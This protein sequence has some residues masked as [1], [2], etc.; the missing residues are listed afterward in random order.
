LTF[1]DDLHINILKFVAGHGAVVQPASINVVSGYKQAQK[2]SGKHQ[3]GFIRAVNCGR[4]RKWGCI[5]VFL[6]TFTRPWAPIHWAILLAH[7]LF[8]N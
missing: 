4:C 2:Y 3:L 5:C 7:V 8:G 6:A 1:A